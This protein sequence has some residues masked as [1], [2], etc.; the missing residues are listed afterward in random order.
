MINLLYNNPANNNADIGKKMSSQ[1]AA[2]P[3]NTNTPNNFEQD[4]DRLHLQMMS[5]VSHDLKTP[6]ASI[7]GSLEIHNKMNAALSA[8]KKTMLLETALEEAYRLDGFISNILDMA[9]LENGMTKV[10]KREYEFEQIIQ[11][12]ILKIANLKEKAEIKV[13]KP[14]ELVMCETDAS[15]LTRAFQCILDNAIKH[16]GNEKPKIQI[17]Y[18]QVNDQ[19]EMH[20]K[21]DGTGIPHGEEEK[22]FNKYT[23][24]AKKDHKNAGTGLGLTL[25][26]AIIQ[27]LGGH[28]HLQQSDKEGPYQGACFKIVIPCK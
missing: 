3:V 22:I 21:D 12:C 18:T 17:D 19:I 14:S 9:R 6:L 13:V 8:E 28:I 2:T 11:D 24:I 5:A 4:R 26:R 1:D 7:I 23:R 27:L 25:A 20:V 15:L 10:H 16:S